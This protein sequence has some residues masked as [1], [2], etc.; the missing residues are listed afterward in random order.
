MYTK[1]LLTYWIQLSCK[2]IP[3][4]RYDGVISSQ[5]ISSR[6]LKIHAGASLFLGYLD[7]TLINVIG[8]NKG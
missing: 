8:S 6:R 5:M 3:R 2:F 4:A 7:D 1:S